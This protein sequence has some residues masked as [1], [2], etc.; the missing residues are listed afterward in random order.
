MEK[1][2]FQKR[3]LTDRGIIANLQVLE[4]DMF[5]KDATLLQNQLLHEESKHKLIITELE[6]TGLLPP[7]LNDITN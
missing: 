7:E 2:E 3:L 5:M 6:V 1:I 4:L